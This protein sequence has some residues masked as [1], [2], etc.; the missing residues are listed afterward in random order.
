MPAAAPHCTSNF[1]LSEPVEQAYDLTVRMQQ[2][3]LPVQA[4]AFVVMAAR[5]GA[6][7][8]A[9]VGGDAAGVLTG[10]QLRASRSGEARAA[11]QRPEAH[12]QTCEEAR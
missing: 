10:A 3:A 8:A 12:L 9:V 2:V 6:H 11:R 1:V 5:G 4:A 7:L